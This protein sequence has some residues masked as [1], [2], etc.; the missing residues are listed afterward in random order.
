VDP[1]ATFA[2]VIDPSSNSVKW[3]SR[4]KGFKL[5]AI[6]PIEVKNEPIP[7]VSYLLW[8]FLLITVSLIVYFKRSEVYNKNTKVRVISILI[9]G[10]ILFPFARPAMGISVF[11]H[12]KPTLE[13][14]AIILNDLLSNVYRAFDKKQEDAV[15]DRLAMSVTN[16]QLTDIY[17]QNRQSMAL[18]NRGGARATVDEVTITNLY[19]INKAGKGQYLADAEWTDR[20]SVNHF[21]HTHYRQNKY[22]AMVTFRI[23][24]EIW[25]ISNIEI[26]DARRLY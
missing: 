26:L 22:R 24:N 8:L 1:H 2:G 14:G 7:I 12:G 17:L 19:E 5:P 23:E 18:E 25:K 10:F 13:K 6:E 9:L 16:Q 15:Y 4:I 21:G 11:S 20:G 3:E